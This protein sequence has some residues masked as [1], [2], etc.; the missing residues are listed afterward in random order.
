[1][2]FII[3]KSS[4]PIDSGLSDKLQNEIAGIMETIP[5]KN[6]SNTT[7]CISDGYRI[8]KEL[9]PV[10]A[11]FIEVRMYKESPTE[12]KKAFAEKL[13]KVVENVLGIPPSNTTINFNEFQEWAS[14]GGYF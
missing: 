13:F 6:V 1:M 14:N 8:Y 11:V 4:K 9:K 3:I 7:F 5:G 12:S 10:E 2:P